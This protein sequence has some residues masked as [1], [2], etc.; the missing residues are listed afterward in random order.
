MKKLASL[1]TING[2]VP[3][4]ALRFIALSVNEKVIV[5]TSA[6]VVYSFS[7]R[8]KRHT[9]TSVKAEQSETTVCAYCG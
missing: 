1:V 9:M 3:T 8:K 6:S 5:I 4:Y 2:L 7:M